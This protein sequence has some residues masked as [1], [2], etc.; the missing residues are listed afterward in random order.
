MHADGVPEIAVQDA[1]PV[2]EI[3]GAMRQIERVLVAQGGDVGRGCDLAQHLL[4][5]VAGDQV[6]EQENQ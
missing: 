4:N 2:M 6:N 5:R 1:V 3:L